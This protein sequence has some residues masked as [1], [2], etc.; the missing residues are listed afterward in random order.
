MNKLLIV[1][2]P[3]ATGKTKLAL[4]LAKKF[5]GELVSADSR[6]V[7]KG[8]DSLTGKDRSEEV[9]IW[10]YDIVDTTD[11]FSVAHF[12]R[13]AQVAIDD[14]YKREK[15]PIVVGGTGFYLR[16]LTRTVD[17]ITTPPNYELRKRLNVTPLVK[18]QDELRR[19]NP[20]R[21]NRMNQSDQK[22]SRRLIR[23]IEVATAAE[24]SPRD[25]LPSDV[26]WIGLAAQL[27]VLKNRIARRVVERFEKAV[28]EVR[29]GLPA[30][31][32]ADPLLS[33]IRGQYTKDEAIQSWV[34]AEYAYA[35]RQLTWFRKESS[36]KWFDIS[37]L[38]YRQKVEDRVAGWYTGKS[39]GNQS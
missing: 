20:V 29:D 2:G 35:K 18:L 38:N 15:L 10:L 4:Q 8:L 19:V 36:I 23:A 24:T 1:C 9:P 31:L 22:N 12:V 13:L 32:G 14:I 21:W 7:Y 25:W 33:Y 6:Q 37:D 11:E 39:H 17:T 34:H 16:A 3:T 5:N 26:L 30:I 28:S 27:S